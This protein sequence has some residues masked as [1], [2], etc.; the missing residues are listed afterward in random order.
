M[1]GQAKVAEGQGQM[2]LAGTH[3]FSAC[4]AKQDLEACVDVYSYGFEG[5]EVIPE[6]S[7]F[8]RVALSPVLVV[9]VFLGSNVSCRAMNSGK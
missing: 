5:R 1:D 8:S 3:T 4:E 6:G 9:S 7:N 2:S